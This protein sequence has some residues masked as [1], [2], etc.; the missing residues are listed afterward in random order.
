MKKLP[1]AKMRRRLG[2]WY[3]DMHYPNRR[4]YSVGP[5]QHF[6]DLATWVANR[7]DVGKCVTEAIG[8]R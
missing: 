7:A 4:I 5:F 2:M 6:G 3:A 1:I 8:T